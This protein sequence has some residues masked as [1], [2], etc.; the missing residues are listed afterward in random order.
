MTNLRTVVISARDANA[1]SLM[2]G[3]WPWRHPV[4]REPALALAATLGDARIVEPDRLPAGVVHMESTVT[5]VD[6]SNDKRQTVTVVYPAQADAGAGRIS[7]LSPIGC[8]LIGRREG[9]DTEVLLPT[10]RRFSV[11]IEEVIEDVTRMTMDDT[12]ALAFA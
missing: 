10:G 1:L 2:L 8:A 4:E 7:V 12:D 11:R 5:Y 3:D 6:C 9:S